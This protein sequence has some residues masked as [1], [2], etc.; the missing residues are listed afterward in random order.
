M[1]N[2]NSVK[3]AISGVISGNTLPRR[4]YNKVYQKAQAIKEQQLAKTFESERLEYGLGILELLLGINFLFAIFNASALNLLAK[5]LNVMTF[6]FTA[7]FYALFGKDPSYA[8][9]KGELANLAAMVIYPIITW[10][11]IAMIRLNKRKQAD[12][13]SYNPNL[14]V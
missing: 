3:L 11:I 8:L 2:V 13:F 12:V 9:S 4:V 1:A 5:L 6:P 7:P 10:A 14:Q